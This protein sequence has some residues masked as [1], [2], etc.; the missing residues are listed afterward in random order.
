[1]QKPGINLSPSNVAAI[2]AALESS[3]MSASELARRVG[4][5]RSAISKVL[6]AQRCPSPAL[7]IRICDTLGLT[8]TAS[9]TRIT[10]KKK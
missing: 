8:L 2:R 5:G 9:E 3:E 7:L 4:A 10:R 1:M 6:H